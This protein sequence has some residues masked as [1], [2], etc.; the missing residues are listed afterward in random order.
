VITQ[1]PR[2]QQRTNRSRTVSA[3]LIALSANPLIAGTLRLV[4]TA[5]QRTLT[6]GLDEWPQPS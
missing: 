1:H 4:H 3:A 6:P 5:P 2:V